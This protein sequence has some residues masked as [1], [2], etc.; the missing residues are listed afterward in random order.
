LIYKAITN[1]FYGIGHKFDFLLLCTGKLS[2]SYQDC[3]YPQN[4]TQSPNPE[5]MNYFGTV[6]PVKHSSVRIMDRL[7]VKTLVSCPGSLFSI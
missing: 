2:L 1:E 5:E 7:P 4:I 6:Y 3:I